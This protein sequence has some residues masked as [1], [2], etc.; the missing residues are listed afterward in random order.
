VI[1]DY[2]EAFD[3]VR[4][5][6]DFVVVNVSSPNTPGLRG[7]QGQEYARALL[8]ALLGR[9]GQ[10]TRLLLKIAPDLDDEKLEELLSVVEEIGIAGVVAANTTVARTGLVTDA[11]RLEAVGAGGLSGAPLRERVTQ[12]VRRVRTRL[13]RTVAIVGVGGVENAQHAL[14]LMRAGA[15]LVQIY[16]GFVYEGPAAP[17]RMARELLRAVE[18]QRV[19]N[20]AELTKS[21]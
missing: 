19:A 20:L 15:D 7:L 2:V 8:A 17:A 10:R 13:G 11:K 21:A 18:D 3:R 1:A 4:D 16:T 9:D 14:T 5:L 6:A 12:M